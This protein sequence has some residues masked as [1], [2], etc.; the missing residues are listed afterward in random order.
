MRKRGMK[1]AKTTEG[2]TIFQSIEKVTKIAKNK[3]DKSK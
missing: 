2:V 1:E 3:D